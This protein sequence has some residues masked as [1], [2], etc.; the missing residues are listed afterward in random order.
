[1]KKAA[2]LRAIESPSVINGGDFV[3]GDYLTHRGQGL[4]EAG[5]GITGLPKQVGDALARMRLAGV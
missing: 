2:G 1:M 3:F 4:A 5:A